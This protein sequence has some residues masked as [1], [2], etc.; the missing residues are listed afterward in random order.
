MTA[1]FAYPV[2]LLILLPPAVAD[3][4]RARPVSIAP[5]PN[6]TAWFERYQEA[7]NGPEST[8]EM[9][10][11]FKVGPGGSLDIF[12]MSGDVVVTGVAGDEIRIKGTKRVWG[13]GAKA[14]L[15]DIVIDVSETAGRVEVRS[16]LGRARKSRAEVDFTIEVPFGAAVSA[17]SLAGDIKVVRVRGDVQIDS[18]SGTIEAVGTPRLVR[19]KTLSGDVMM[20]D[21][22]A[23][24]G[25]SA[26]TVSGDLV[27]KG[28]T[29]RSLDVVTVSGDV[30]LV[31]AVCE[32]A[33][34]RTVNGDVQYVGPVARGGR[35]E[36]N[37]HSGDIRF[38]LVGNGGFELSARTFSGDV[39]AEM[40]LVMAPRSDASDLPGLPPLNQ[41]VR[42]TFGDG[43]ALLVVRTFSGSVVVG[44]VDA[45]RDAKSKDKA[46]KKR[47]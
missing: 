8:E 17:R 5:A 7:R 21:A 3:A 1:R 16:M 37:S 36:L 46:D 24:D 23:A 47:D 44:R 4:Q 30:T 26:S 11:T 10:K 38:D 19:L 25:L 27:A 39:R 34:L 29:A 42:G 35:Y 12:N 22:A 14:R 41:E 28:L 40:P 18:T 2:A 9:S 32:R 20:D 45:H 31:N 13:G 6:R 43:S 15:D 33:Q